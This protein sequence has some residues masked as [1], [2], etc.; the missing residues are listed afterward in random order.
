M[1]SGDYTG[2]I[3]GFAK[4]IQMAP[5]VAELQLNLGVAYYW[6][7]RPRDAVAP[8]RKALE[9]NPRLASARYFLGLSLVLRFINTI[10]YNMA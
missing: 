5:A 8:C 7:G 6:V 4:L 3:Q 10:T 1:Q 2:A 9:L